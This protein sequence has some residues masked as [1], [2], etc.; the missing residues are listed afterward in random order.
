MEKL[1]KRK[2]FLLAISALAA[3]IVV[4]AA[5][6]VIRG[7]SGAREEPQSQGP[8]IPEGQRLV[9]DLYEGQRLIPDF[10]IPA[11]TY[12]TAK[13]VEEDGLIRYQDGAAVWGVDV[14]EFQ[15]LIDWQ[16][17]KDAGAGFAILRL[18]WRGSTEGGLNLDTTFQQNYEGAA[19][20]GLPVG[21]YF[22]SQA[23][24][25][26][27]ARE[28]AAFVLDA[29]EGKTITYPVVFDWEPPIPSDSLPAQ[30]LRAYGMDGDQVSRFA[31]AFCEK[32]AEAG[33][34]PCVYTNKTMAYG[35]FDLELLG[36]YPLWYAEYQPAPSLY[37]HF[38]L[39]QY[40]DSAAV[41]GIPGEADVNICF[42]PY[43]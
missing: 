2:L 14:S 37:Y 20:A 28:E 5:V 34:T 24:T 43:G 29:L 22:F 25:E 1:D 8:L 39:W 13:F 40:T 41:P 12:D 36:D 31:L 4:I 21:V 35:F 42:V 7:E 16:Q 10:D 11:N 3:L 19:A 26:E 33:Y 27:E 15:G 6:L 17:V 30:D 38:D 18:G 9:E 23:V 32:V